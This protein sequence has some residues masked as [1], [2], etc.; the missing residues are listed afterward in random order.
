MAECVVTTCCPLHSF[1]WT[2]QLE[3]NRHLFFELNLGHMNADIQYSMN[4]R[5]HS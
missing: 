4:H 5:G 1:V 3:V 2:R